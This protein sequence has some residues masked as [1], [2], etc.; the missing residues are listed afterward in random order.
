MYYY[1][2]KVAVC[3]NL[4][5][6][7]LFELFR[8]TCNTSSLMTA[9]KIQGRSN[10]DVH[11]LREKVRASDESAGR[12]SSCPLDAAW[13][14]AR[15]SRPSRPSPAQNRRSTCVGRGT[16]RAAPR[17]AARYAA[18]PRRYRSDV[19]RDRSSLKSTLHP[20]KLYPKTSNV[21]LVPKRHAL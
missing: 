4:N 7:L 18:V 19:F 14:A 13:G 1:N 17:S 6:I 12:P 16:S 5:K 15:P 8:R 20:T 3:K 21:N 9:I 2:E 10:T 11:I